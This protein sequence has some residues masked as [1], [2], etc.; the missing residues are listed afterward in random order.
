VL[1]E[2]ARSAF[3]SSLGRSEQQVFNARLALAG[4]QKTLRE[5][6]GALSKKH[7]SEVSG[8]V[9]PVLEGF[10]DAA[11]AHIKKRR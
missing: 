5:L 6:C 8:I 7:A 3:I 2:T 10:F 1:D 11:A 9:D 4:S